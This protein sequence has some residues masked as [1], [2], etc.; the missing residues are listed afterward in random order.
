M[1]NATNE[2][3]KRL[4]KAFIGLR[5]EEECE[6]FLTDLF[7]ISELQSAEQRLKIAKMLSEKKTSQYVS[8]ETGAS[9]ATVSRVNRCLKYGTGGYKDV[10]E[11]LNKGNE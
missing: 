1:Q 3:R 10:L 4:Y 9:T 8:E 6:A 11:K 5:T 7:S 2:D